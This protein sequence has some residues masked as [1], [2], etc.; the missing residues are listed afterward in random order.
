[1]GGYIQTTNREDWETPQALFD[2]LNAEFRFTLDAAALPSNA[3]CAPY[4]TPEDDGLS[5]PWTG[6]V[7]CNPPYGK[8]IADWMRKVWEAAQA[9]ATVVLLVPSRTDARWFH[10][11]ALKGEVRFIRGRLRFGGSTENAP[12]PSVLVIFRPP[13]TAEEAS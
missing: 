9:G 1:V 11:Y 6:S 12:F 13:Q 3:K 8:Q 2:Q 10:D 5:K 4:Y 7:W